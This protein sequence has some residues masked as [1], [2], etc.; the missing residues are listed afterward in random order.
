MFDMNNETPRIIQDVNTRLNVM[1]N[2]HRLTLTTILHI[3]F[4]DGLT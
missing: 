2:H 4:S 3:Q 1:W